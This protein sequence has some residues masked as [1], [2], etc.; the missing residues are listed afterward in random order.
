MKYKHYV[1]PKR[2]YV[3]AKLKVSI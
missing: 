2:L 3:S 1:L